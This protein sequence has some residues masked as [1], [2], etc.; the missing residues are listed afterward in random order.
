MGIASLHDWGEASHEAHLRTRGATGDVIG[1]QEWGAT[2]IPMKR[3]SGASRHEARS[4]GHRL[5][6]PHTFNHIVR[7]RDM[8]LAIQHVKKRVKQEQYK[9]KIPTK[10]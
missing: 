6:A 1:A 2:G 8:D 9:S 4:Q 10:R 3:G 5:K 7:S